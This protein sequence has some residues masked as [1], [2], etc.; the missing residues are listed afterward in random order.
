MTVS[1]PAA[2]SAASAAA[3]RAAVEP[4]DG[5]ATPTGFDSQLHAA[6]QR[7]EP[8]SANEA[9]GGQQDERQPTSAARSPRDPS[10]AAVP[11][12]KPDVAAAVPVPVPVQAEL[13][14]VTAADG[15]APRREPGDEPAPAVADA[16]L[17]LLGS[18]LAG[19]WPPV[20]GG[21]RAVAGAPPSGGKGATGDAQAAAMLQLA[22]AASPAA[23]PVNI[24]PLAASMLAPAQAVPSAADALNKQ[25]AQA[26]AAAAVL[27][28]PP[29]AA[30]PPA[31]HQL[32]LPTSPTSPSF[33]QDLGQQLVWLSGQN[34]KQAR[35][36]LHPEELG[37]LDVSVSVS[38][39][40][41]DVVFSAQHAAAV[42]AVQQSLPL[43]D[44]MLA[45]HGLSLGHA[46][47]G[48]HDRGDRRG[49][50]GGGGALEEIADIHGAAPMT[51]AR[52]G[53]LDAFA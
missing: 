53:L 4:R 48:Q 25:A 13:A 10:A 16:M 33:A 39:G 51:V 42:P 45:R 44:Q 2:P 6:R 50:A 28:A 11:A 46:E 35:I 52:I 47:V 15:S 21:A 43:L 23:A 40:R 12:A 8:D 3:S 24:V 19:V 36:R 17:A 1:A 27:P 41:V 49:H 9:S 31:V 7:Q 20:A 22:V 30:A 38:H 34:V 5:N 32:Q 37:S 14:D 26:H 29:A 18:S